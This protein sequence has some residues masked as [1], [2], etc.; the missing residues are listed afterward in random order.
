MSWQYDADHRATSAVELSRR[1]MQFK[2]TA[3][4]FNDFL[5]DGEAEARTLLP[6]RHIGFQNAMAIID[7]QSLAIVDDIHHEA[8]TP[9]VR[10]RPDPHPARQFFSIGGNSLDCFHRILDQIAESLGQHAESNEPSVET[11]QRR[12]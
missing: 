7:R 9:L 3:M 8:V 11:R 12:E 10:C 1:I 5:D 4:L 2:L 6:H